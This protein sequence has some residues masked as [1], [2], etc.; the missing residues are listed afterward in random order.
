VGGGGGG[1]APKYRY[2]RF[3]VYNYLNS[4]LV[5]DIIV[6]KTLDRGIIMISSILPIVGRSNDKFY[7]G[8]I[9]TYALY[10]CT[11]YTSLLPEL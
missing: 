4:K 7:T 3:S 11:H 5:L 10:K 1:G 2:S 6:S 8:V 9:T